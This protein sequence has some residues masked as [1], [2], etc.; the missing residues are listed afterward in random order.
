MTEGAMEKISK[1]NEKSAKLY[2]EV[3]E[4]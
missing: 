4:S 1:I 2:K 3:L